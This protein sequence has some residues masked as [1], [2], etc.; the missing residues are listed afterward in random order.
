MTQNAKTIWSV[1]FFL[2]LTILFFYTPDLFARDKNMFKNL[3]LATRNGLFIAQQK[4]DAWHQ[5]GH[6]LKGH[7]LTSVAVCGRHILAGTRNGIWLSDDGGENVREVTAGLSI[8]YVRWLACRMGSEGLLLAGTEPAGIFVSDDGANSWLAPP[9]VFELRDKHGWFL[10]YSP[11]AGC[12]RDFAFADPNSDPNRLYAAVEVGGVLVSYN[13]GETWQLVDGSDGNP[14]LSRSYDVT[15]HPDVHSITVHPSSPDLITAPTGGGLYRSEDGGKTWHH[16]YST[17]C[18]AAWVNPDN[19]Q[20][21]IFGPADGVSRNGRIEESHDGGKTWHNASSGTDAPWPRHMVERFYQ[22]DNQ[23][24]A[25][26]SNG[27]LWSTRLDKVDWNRTL[28]EVE[29]VRSVAISD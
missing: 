21:I 13:S 9:E 6:V 17:Y 12:V 24:L 5:S 25:I 27:E 1:I 18:R 20:H 26:L 10:P 4:N 8:L 11:E 28:S 19:P 7:D 23:L 2:T 14:D 16:L 29:G 22:V 3:Y 15:I